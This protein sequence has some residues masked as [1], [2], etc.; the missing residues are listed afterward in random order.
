MKLPF[1]LH[2]AVDSIRP[3]QPGKPTEEL[4]RELGLQDTVK[5]ASNENPLG[6]SPRGPFRLASV[7]R[8]RETVAVPTAAAI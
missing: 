3:Y 1:T 8:K 6:P 7:T 4:E 5:L 2:P